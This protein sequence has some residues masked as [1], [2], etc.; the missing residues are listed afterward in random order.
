[1]WGYAYISIV[2]NLILYIIIF[3]FHLVSY[4]KILARRVINTC[5]TMSSKVRYH[6][7]HLKEKIAQKMFVVL[8]LQNSSQ[9][10]RNMDEI[11]RRKK[12]PLKTCMVLPYSLSG[13]PHVSMVRERLRDFVSDNYLIKISPHRYK[14][15][16]QVFMIVRV[17]YEYCYQLPFIFYSILMNSA[18]PNS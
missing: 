10:V 13:S 5:A 9:I 1:M 18:S 15:S 11:E 4:V 17:Q 6:G 16:P 2:A 14:Y 12:L 7:S 3:R 8:D